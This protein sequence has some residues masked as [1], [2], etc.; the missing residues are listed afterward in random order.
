M[1]LA[2]ERDAK[3]LSSVVCYEILSAGPAGK[4]LARNQCRWD[5]DA[6]NE[7]ALRLVHE[8]RPRQSSYLHSKRQYRLREQ[9]FQRS[10]PEQVGADAG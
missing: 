9:T 5:G 7:G 1:E 6:F 10:G 4:L 2:T 3:W 8:S